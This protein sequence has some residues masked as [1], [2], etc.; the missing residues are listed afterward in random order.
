MISI[1]KK[2]IQEM[3]DDGKQ[4]EVRCQFCDKI[5]NFDIEAETGDITVNNEKKKGTFKTELETYD[6]SFS[7]HIGVG[8]INIKTIE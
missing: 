2:D 6:A 7:A 1:G 4:I 3:I 5:Y 8:N